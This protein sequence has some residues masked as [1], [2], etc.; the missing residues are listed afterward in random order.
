MNCLV[1][2]LSGRLY[3]G[4]F[5]KR[6][7]LLSLRIDWLNRMRLLLSQMLRRVRLV[8]LDVFE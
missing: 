1:E 7:C 2:V 8:A 6:V 4:L 3:C 5:I